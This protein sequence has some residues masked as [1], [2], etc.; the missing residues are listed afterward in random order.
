MCYSVKS[1]LKTVALSLFSII[2]L[3]SSG[4]P[5]FQWIGITLIGWCG[6]QFA[7]LLLWNTN[8]RQGCTLM[9]KIITMSII[10]LALLLQPLGSLWGS[11]YAIPWLKLSLFR[12]RFIVIYSLLIFLCIY[13]GHF[14]EQSKNCSIVT[15]K[16]HL[17]W[18]TSPYKKYGK[19]DYS[20]YFLWC[21]LIIFPFIF[22][23]NKS[24]LVPILLFI[25]PLFGFIYGMYTDGKP[26][27][28]CYYT[29]YTSFTAIILLFIQQ[30]GIYK[31][32]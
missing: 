31:L 32:I 26:S 2:Y 3:L 18:N 30:T 16:G 7:E 4:I 9:N 22:F 28:W 14:Y 25:T 27:I 12:K 17:H 11:L 20:V 10:P 24:Y 5:H 8:P 13:Y 23:W 6:M 19:H 29:S 1:S 15:L 21:I